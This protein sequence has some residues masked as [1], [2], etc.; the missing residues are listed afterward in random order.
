MT[1]LT[2]IVPTADNEGRT[3]QPVIQDWEAF[4]LS[5]VG[6]YTRDVVNGAWLDNGTVYR[7]ESYRYVVTGEKVPEVQA[8]LGHWAVALRQKELYTST[9]RVAVKLVSPVAA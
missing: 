4:L 8:S 1:E 5:T 2:V 7:D 3:L 9:R 6:G